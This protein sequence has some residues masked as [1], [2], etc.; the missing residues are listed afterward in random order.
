MENVEKCGDRLECLGWAGARAENGAAAIGI[1]EDVDAD[2]KVRGVPAHLQQ[3]ASSDLD[4]PLCRN[5]P[6]D[7]CWL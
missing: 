4:G 3:L 6:H 5:S 2:E 1:G 7:E